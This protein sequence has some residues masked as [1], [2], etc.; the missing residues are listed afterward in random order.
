M[1]NP[2][3]PKRKRGGNTWNRSAKIA[4]Q[5]ILDTGSTSGV[6]A[7]GNRKGYSP[8]MYECFE[9]EETK[10][11]HIIPRVS[12]TIRQHLRLFPQK[13]ETE[14]R[15]FAQRASNGE[16]VH[17]SD[18]HVVWKSDKTLLRQGKPDPFGGER[19]TKFGRITSRSKRRLTEMEY[20]E[21]VKIAPVLSPDLKIDD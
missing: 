2:Y 7:E 20:Q 16:L 13:I 8:A 1:K 21:V 3:N 9:G 12:T 6:I 5:S 14:P 18:E 11:T 17:G 4:A 10:E 15:S 19:G